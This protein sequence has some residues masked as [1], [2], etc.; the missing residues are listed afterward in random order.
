LEK[1]AYRPDREGDRVTDH[2][3]SYA[4]RDDTR[5][6][7]TYL[8]DIRDRMQRAVDRILV[9][10]QILLTEGA[11]GFTHEVDLLGTSQR[12]YAGFTAVPGA[13]TEHFGC[14]LAVEPSGGG[15][16]SGS[17]ADAPPLD[18]SAWSFTNLV[19]PQWIPECGL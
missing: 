2:A 18:G 16:H 9:T 5:N 1:M 11:E 14:W 3:Y 6:E 19:V 15:Q 13:K 8:Y 10:L 12:H 17:S 7:T 4:P